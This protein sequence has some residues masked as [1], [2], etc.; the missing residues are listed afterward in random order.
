MGGW[1]FRAAAAAS[2]A[3]CVA[4][5]VW[6]ALRFGG[7][8]ATTVVD[9]LLMTV[10][11]AMAGAACWWRALAHE[12][13]RRERNFWLLWGASYIAFAAGMI[14]WDYAQLFRDVDLPYPSYGDIGFLGAVAL[15]GAALF[16]SPKAGDRPSVTVRG[17]LDGLILTSALF[18]SV[19][20][21]VLQQIVTSSNVSLAIRR[22]DGS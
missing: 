16:Y 12:P 9:D 4:F 21:L 10:T 1:A 11:P 20:H 13:G 7:K 6:I 17:L 14:Y 5:S 15:N 2:A 18:F 19:W 8:T 22:I 3:I